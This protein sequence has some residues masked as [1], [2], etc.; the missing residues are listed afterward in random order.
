MKGSFESGWGRGF[1]KGMLPA[2]V[3][4]GGRKN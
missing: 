3:S 2:W 1:Q 4:V